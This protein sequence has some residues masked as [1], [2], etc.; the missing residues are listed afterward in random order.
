M[1]S[2]CICVCVCVCVSVILLYCIKTAKRRITQIMPHDSPGTLVFWYQSS[3]RNSNGITPY[4][5]DKCRWGGSKIGHSRQKTRYNSKTVQYRRVV[6]IKVESEV[7]CS[8]SNGHVSDHLRWPIT[9]QTTPIFAFFVALHNFVVSKHK[10]LWHGM[11]LDGNQMIS[12]RSAWG[13]RPH[14]HALKS[15]QN[16]I[17]LTDLISHLIWTVQGS[18]LRLV[19]RWLSDLYAPFQRSVSLA[20]SCHRNFSVSSCPWRP[21]AL[22]ICA[23]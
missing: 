8:L 15:I 16:H 7:I 9:P 12:D 19:H 11:C 18:G 20:D 10:D 3:R 23:V 21:I 6:S 5:G 17:A 4:G 2:S 14:T 13:V 22:F 1:P